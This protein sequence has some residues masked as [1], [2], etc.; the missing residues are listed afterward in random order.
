MGGDMAG[1]W[2]PLYNGNIAHTVNSLQPFGGWSGTGQ[3][4]QVLAQVYKYDQLN[5]LKT[6]RGYT[7]LDADND[8]ALA[9]ATVTDMYKS[10]YAYDANGNITEAHRWDQHG[11][12]YDSLYYH[13]H[14]A[15]GHLVRNRLY[16]LQ[17]LAPDNVVTLGADGVEDLPYTDDAFNDGD[18]EHNTLNN[19]R[20]DALGNLIR[21]EREEIASIE[22]TVAGKVKRVERTTGSGRE[23]LT[24]GYGADG[25][26]IMKQV[27]ENPDLGTGHREYYVRDAQG[28]IMAIYRYTN[29]GTASFRV[30]ER[31]IYGSSRLGSYDRPRQLLGSQTIPPVAVMSHPA[32]R[33]E[34]TDHLGNVNTVVTG[35][36][37]PGN[38]A[39]SAYQAEVVSAQSYEPFGS[40]LPGRNHNSGASRHLFQGQETDNE[41]HGTTGTSYAFTYRLHDARVGRFWSIDPLAAKYPHNSPYAFSE[42][43]VIDGIEL[44]GLEVL[45]IGHEVAGGAILG[46]SAGAGIAIG[47]DGAYSYNTYGGGVSTSVHGSWQLTAT[48][49]PTMP[50]VKDASGWSYSAGAGIGE[51]IVGGAS[52]SYSSGYWGLGL[53][54]GFGGG[55][56]LLGPASVDI[57]ASHTKLE[58]ISESA[59]WNDLEFLKK[60]STGLHDMK[61]S[62][63]KDIS[64]QNKN[65]EYQQKQRENRP[66]ESAIWDSRI[67]K[68]QEKI[69]SSRE[70][71]NGINAGIETIDN[72]INELER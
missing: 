6:A 8:W 4:A 29:T 27:G 53:S 64:K 46:G 58:P 10:T 42:N 37:L 50:S 45:L 54:A 2:N 1:T 51:G 18:G 9:G 22:W 56:G 72:R 68:T 38:G 52:T 28:N 39:G 31:P 13:Y 26:R 57:G 59:Q 40:L 35:R 61:A 32:K 5:R 14:E 70:M 21:D 41:M 24:F 17:D 19:Y 25:Q 69:S 30:I 65:L 33:Y 66:N 23:P 49:Y 43:R 48:F 60:S 34:L 11:E 15:G 71:I 63:E 62:I 44:E 47:P 3:S 7:G 67:Q 36:L 20:Y 55:I 12:R 16:H